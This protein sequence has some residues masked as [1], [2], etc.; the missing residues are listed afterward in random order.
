MS[1]HG[2]GYGAAGCL[3]YFDNNIQRRV[4][5]T[6]RKVS[7]LYLGRSPPILTC[8]ASICE[9]LTYR[10]EMYGQDVNHL[11]MKGFDLG[12]DV[13][14]CDK[15]R[16]VWQVLGWSLPKVPVS[17]DI[18]VVGRKIPGRAIIGCTPC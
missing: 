12:S 16:R 13:V 9:L 5:D 17:E 2:R 4:R 18:Y 10:I 8:L 11:P 15:T 14:H 7:V 1:M 3:Q 6:H